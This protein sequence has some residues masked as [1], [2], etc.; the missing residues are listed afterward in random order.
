[1]PPNF[2]RNQGHAIS[3]IWVQFDPKFDFGCHDDK[4]MSG[5][6]GQQRIK[7]NELTV[8]TDIDS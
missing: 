5:K 4:N 2:T 7:E 6:H 8:Q 3:N 1:M